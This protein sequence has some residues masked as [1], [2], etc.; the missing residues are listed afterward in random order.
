MAKQFKING[1]TFKPN[2]DFQVNYEPCHGDGSGRNLSAE[3]DLRIV[4]W[5]FT[6]SANFTN[7]TDNAISNLMKQL[8]A[9]E[10]MQV[11][12]PS[13]LEGKETTG[14]FYVSALNINH[15]V[16]TENDVNMW[17]ISFKL[18]EK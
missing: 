16:M 15:K 10:F 4:A 3:M 12:Y 17:D 5:K 13:P 11:T 9:S 7:M 1:I 18:I 2:S 14:T 8:T 6:V